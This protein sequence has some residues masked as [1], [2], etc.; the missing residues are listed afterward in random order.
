MAAKSSLCVGRSDL[1]EG[2]CC[3][4]RS[5]WSY[6]CIQQHQYGC[7]TLLSSRCDCSCTHGTPAM[8]AWCAQSAVR[9]VGSL[10]Q[11]SW[12]TAASMAGKM[13]WGD[14]LDEDTS[15]VLPERSVTGPDAKGYK[16]VTEYKK[17]DKGETVR[18]VTK[19]RLSKVEKKLYAVSCLTAIHQ[20]TGRL[21][22]LAIA[23]VLLQARP[24]EVCC[25][26][27]ASAL[28]PLAPISLWG[29]RT[30]DPNRDSCCQGLPCILCHL[31]SAWVPCA[32]H[33]ISLLL[34]HASSGLA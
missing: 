7:L 14:T 3:L 2:L 21:N 27:Q 20:R 19:T 34:C 25:R 26:S 9:E 11:E 4:S 31:P 12:S 1:S 17:N 22:V 6:R 13:R 32:R 16:T 33:P 30:A 18:M 15:D 29:L 5:E 10:P 23:C 24:L 28:Q 8:Q